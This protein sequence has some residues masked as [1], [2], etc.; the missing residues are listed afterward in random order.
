MAPHILI[1][2]RDLYYI[3]VIINTSLQ[4]HGPSLQSEDVLAG[5]SF[6]CHHQLLLFIVPSSNPPF[7]DS[8]VKDPIPTSMIFNNTKGKY[9]KRCMVIESVRNRHLQMP[10]C[11]KDY[12]SQFGPSGCDRGAGLLYITLIIPHI[13]CL[14]DDEPGFLSRVAWSILCK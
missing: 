7:L 14:D 1:I 6:F 13:T 12:I 10:D 8:F 2:L 9:L 3:L 11:L 4:C 5:G